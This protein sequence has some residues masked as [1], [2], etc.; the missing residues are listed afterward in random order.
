M[1]A[2]T[3]LSATVMLQKKGKPPEEDSVE[4]VV[5]DIFI[6]VDKDATSALTRREFVAWACR[7]LEPPAGADGRGGAGQGCADATAL[8]T[9]FKLLEPVAAVEAVGDGFEQ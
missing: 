6:E 8:L 1:L 5:D 3:V 2:Y 4:A 7:C 9:R